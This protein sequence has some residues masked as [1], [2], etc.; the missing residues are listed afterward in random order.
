M[1]RHVGL[2]ARV[3]FTPYTPEQIERWAVYQAPWS[4]SSVGLLTM[5]QL[6]L[7]AAF[8]YRLRANFVIWV[9]LRQERKR[10][11]GSGTNKWNRIEKKKT[12]AHYA[13]CLR[14]CF[15]SAWGMG[16]TCACI[17]WKAET[18]TSA[19]FLRKMLWGLLEQRCHKNFPSC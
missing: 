12:K 6:G 4:L 3:S 13:S 2:V 18:K 14:Q 16:K 11:E 17:F 19:S 15:K 1:E 8:V 7:L 5:H 10:E 9:R